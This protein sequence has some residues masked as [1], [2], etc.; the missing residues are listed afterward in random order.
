MKTHQRILLDVPGIW[1]IIQ[2]PKLLKQKHGLMWKTCLLTCTIGLTRAPKGK[3]GSY[4]VFTLDTVFLAHNLCAS[5][6]SW[7]SANTRLY[8][9]LPVHT[10]GIV[11]ISGTRTEVLEWNSIAHA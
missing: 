10:G 7:N 5:V 9:L 3:K 6:L 1:Y 8:Y 11:V 2:L 4:T